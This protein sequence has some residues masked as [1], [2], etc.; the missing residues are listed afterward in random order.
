MRSA[1]SRPRCWRW[2]RPAAS[3]ASGASTRVDAMT[4]ALSRIACAALCAASVLGV[5]AAAEPHPE[6]QLIAA[7]DDLNNGKVNEAWQT[8]DALVKRQPNFRLAQMVYGALQ[9][10]R[11]G[12]PGVQ[13]AAPTGTELDGLV[14]EARLRLQARQEAI[15]DGSV[16]DVVL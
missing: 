6:A 2:R 1:T 12:R 14:E 4:R 13:A 5:A 16:P 8:L 11:A 15:P 10:A 3:G 7:L 9:A